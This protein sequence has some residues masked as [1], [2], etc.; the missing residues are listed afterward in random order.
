MS[1][2]RIDNADDMHRAIGDSLESLGAFEY[3][4]AGRRIFLKPNLTYPTHRPGVTTSPR[5]LRAVLATLADAGS[6]VFVGEGDGGYGSWSADTAFDGHGLRELCVEFGATLVN[7]SRAPSRTVELEIPGRTYHLGLPVILLDETDTFITLPV[8]KIHAMVTYSGAVKNQWGCIPDPMRLKLHPD[9]ETIIWAVNERLAPRLVI[10]D[11]EYVLDR[12]GPL[13]GDAVYMNRVV[14]A[15]DILAFDVAVLERIMRLNPA[16]I[17]YLLRGRQL[18]YPWRADVVED[19]STGPTHQFE[20]HRT[21]RNRLVAAAFPRQW[22]VDLIWDSRLGDL[23]HRV[24][25]ALAGNPVARERD[26]VV[27]E[28]RRRGVAYMP[29]DEG[30]RP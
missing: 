26:R 22:A 12:N 13:W 6:R 11:A 17:P 25:Y 7:L 4:G 5:L 15:D 24:L 20:L 28:T 1:K 16:A 29:G 2:V 27:Q 10:G 3:L 14:V 9:F 8:P 21:L 30:D 19:R 23:A 18:G